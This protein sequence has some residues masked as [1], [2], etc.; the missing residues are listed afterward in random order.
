MKFSATHAFNC[1]VLIV[2]FSWTSCEDIPLALHEGAH[3]KCT[4]FIS[5]YQILKTSSAI[6]DIWVLAFL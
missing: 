1:I 6:C 2:K 5:N 3:N 4:T